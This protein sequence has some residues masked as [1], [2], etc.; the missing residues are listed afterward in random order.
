ME[1]SV[2]LNNL[3]AILFTRQNLIR[4]ILLIFGFTIFP[5]VVYWAGKLLFSSGQTLSEYYSTTIYGSLSDW[6]MDGMIA[7]G[8]VCVPYI[9]Y[10]IFLLIKDFR[11][12]RLQNE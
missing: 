10:D 9:V 7:W 3:S 6:G 1:I 2:K 4:L 5:A 11:G 12:G 8:I